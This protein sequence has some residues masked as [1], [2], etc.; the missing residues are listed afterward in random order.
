M[1]LSETDNYD[2]RQAIAKTWTQMA[3]AASLT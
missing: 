1:Q 3:I 2:V